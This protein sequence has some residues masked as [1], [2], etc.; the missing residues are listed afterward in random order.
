[1]LPMVSDKSSKLAR[2]R[3]LQPPA[4]APALPTAIDNRHS[5]VTILCWM[6]IGTRHPADKRRV[7]SQLV[8][9]KGLCVR[10]VVPENGAGTARD[11]ELAAPVR[12][13]IKSGPHP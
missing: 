5:R 9:G 8:V 4:P 11:G 2:C 3:H 12:F 13:G 6:Q 1:M 10:C 7:P